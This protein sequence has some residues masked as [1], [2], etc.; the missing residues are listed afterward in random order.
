M[1][2]DLAA[3]SDWTLALLPRLF[4]YPG[5]LFLLASLALLRLASG[6][7]GALAPRAVLRDLAGANALSLAVAWAAV[8]LLPVPGGTLP[9]AP[10]PHALAPLL[11]LSLV[12]D[13]RAVRGREQALAGGAI[14]LV[15][16]VRAVGSEAGAVVWAAVGLAVLAGV[17][18]LGALRDDLAAQARATG[19]VWLWLSAGLPYLPDGLAWLALV[20]LP[21][22]ALALGIMLRV[23][24]GER[25][26]RA[27]SPAI[28]WSLALPSLLAALLLAP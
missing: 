19:W 20:V 24:R 1:T 26:A 9:F 23:A 2:P 11:A 22:A 6:G 15:L 8:G 17:Y 16:L 3:F 28:A 27:A 18:A 5:G 21:A 13:I 14:T 4:L 12:L 10:G 25:G 7:P